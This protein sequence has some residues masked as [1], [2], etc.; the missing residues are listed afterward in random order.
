M[1]KVKRNYKDSVFRRLF[2]NKEA[3]IELY[4]ALS[5]RNYS[6]ETDL[7]I[8]TLENSIFG[9]MKNDL[10]FIIDGRFIILIEHQSTVSPNLPFREFIYLAK[11]YERL[12]FSADV[13]SKEKIRLPVPELYVFYNGTED[14]PVEEELKLSDSFC[15]EC[16]TIAIEA[17]VKVINV[18]YEKNAELLRGCELLADYSKFIYMIRKR[19]RITKDLQKAMEESIETCIKE[20]ILTEFLKK[21]GGEIMSILYDA[22]TRE[23]CEAIR[24]ND[25]YVRGLREGEASGEAR[26]EAKE[27]S[28]I[29]RKMLKMGMDIKLISEATGLTEEE[30][31]S[32]S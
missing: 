1:N 2:E 25:G 28:S 30:I 32:L 11:E 23:E 15:C 13:Y 10:A 18:N 20:G 29:A 31:S 22:L 8:I 7:E 26:G 16:D 9:D 19:E 3:L 12:F 27:K 5:G 4:N 6:T 17:I 14:R 21:N 24:E